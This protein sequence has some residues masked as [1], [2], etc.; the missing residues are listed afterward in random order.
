MKLKYKLMS[1]M[2]GLLY[3]PFNFYLLYKILEH[4]RATELMW[5]L[6][7]MLVPLAVAFAILSKLAEWEEA[8]ER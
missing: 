7:W 5:F 4:I 3:L 8:S 6:Y 2:L 1:L